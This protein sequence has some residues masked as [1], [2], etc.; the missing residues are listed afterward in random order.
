MQQHPVAPRGTTNHAKKTSTVRVKF[1][2]INAGRRNVTLDLV[3]RKAVQA[4]V[5][6][7]VLSE[8][9]KKTATKQGWLTDNRRDAALLFVNRGAQVDASGGGDGYVWADLGELTVY[10]CYYS[11][12]VG[13][14]AYE[15][16]I[17]KLGEDVR[18]RGRPAII[19]GDF[20][21]KS[22][23][24][25]SPTEDAR[26][27]VVME[28]VSGSDLIVLNRG[29]RPTFERGSQRSHIDIT[30]C[31][32]G[33]VNKIKYWKVEEEEIL[34]DHN[35]ISYQYSY[36][37]Q[38]APQRNRGG[39]RVTPG[40]LDNFTGALDS[41]LNRE[42]AKGEQTSYTRF[43]ECVVASCDESFP[44]R[45]TLHGKRR[46]VHWWGPEVKKCRA[47]CIQK[48]RSLTRTNRNGTQEEKQR[49][50]EDYRESRSIYNRT[51]KEAKR[52]SWKNLVSD[53]DRDEW[54][55]GYKIVVKRMFSRGRKRLSDK[56]QWEI[57]EELFPQVDD[58]GGT[59]HGTMK[60][61][62]PPFTKDEL[63]AAVERIR[64][65]KAP[66]PDGV[67]PI[68]A[69][70]AMAGAGEAFLNIANAALA[71]GVFPEQLK[72]A[73]LVLVPKQGNAGGPEKYRPLSMLNVFGKVLETMVAN[74]LHRQT[75]HGLHPLQ[76][77]FR[78]GRSAVGA[79][80]EVTKIAEEAAKGAAQHKRFCALVTLDIR[81]AFG[82]ARWSEV[83]EELGRREIENNLYN[84]VAS[85]LTDR[86]I[87][88]G[89]NK[90]QLK[91][92]CGV[93]QGSVLGPPLWNILYDGVL[94]VEVPE[95]VTNIAYADDLAMVA[96]AR[97]GD[98]LQSN[99]NKALI[100][101]K[102]WLR[103]RKLV[104]ASEKTEV[105]LL[106]G[107]R[108]LK[109]LTVTV[110]GTD[111]ASVE[112]IKYL[113]V[114][115]DKDRR[116]TE[117][118]RRTVQRATEVAGRLCRIMPNIGGPRSSKRRV[119]C[120]AVSSILMYGAPVWKKA[121]RHKKYVG[122]MAKL[123]RKLALRICSAYRTVSLEAIQVLAGVIPLELIAEEREETNRNSETNKA[124]LR[125]TT[126]HRWQERW[127]ALQGKAEWTRRLIPSISR[128]V[129][130]QHGEVN[131]WMTQFLS[132]HGCFRDY[133]HRFG[134]AENAECVY[135]AAP[136]YTAEHTVFDCPRWEKI[137]MELQ[138]RLGFRVGPE[139]I[140]QTMITDQRK[141]EEIS[142][143]VAGIIQT[144]ENEEKGEAR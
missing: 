24:W 51:I 37:S 135:C 87:L 80:K 101:V 49:A 119:I 99:I 9:N 86:T 59:N 82:T 17:M 120:S 50:K 53:L 126:I 143:T 68:I 21:A 10:S 89:D 55:N 112:C 3:Y 47:I 134:R 31:S 1:L 103:R 117:H 46:E 105:V 76:F 96:V 118:I 14:E 34:G 141:W 107:R 92:T 33:I 81:N 13:Q 94:R 73:R 12:N 100:A 125:E 42:Q 122:M 26:G 110:G 11:P 16:Y 62:G 19:G 43:L 5:D 98:M 91:M 111:V 114:Y 116:M 52:E 123:Q 18:R 45:S 61:D 27:G 36:R 28:W 56:K 121:L 137:R 67:L 136:N 44:K 124:E 77:G 71:D 29:S 48:R 90:K 40:S 131:Y 23:E 35:L 138:V 106:C 128:W 57:A 60:P 39:W 108:N 70:A 63:G 97:T 2:Q 64:L 15:D 88:V 25:G 113:G 95:G 83:M 130:R 79:M 142:A 78:R 129:T 115:F 54:G 72:Q 132:G 69:K 6:L 41:K 20:N 85:Y 133:L 38:V 32:S 93:P 58:Q 30:M 74:R 65:N 139:S 109:S 4:G 104:L 84:L 144:K 8:P 75:A 140:V 22:Y 102:E 7:I 127:S 66:G